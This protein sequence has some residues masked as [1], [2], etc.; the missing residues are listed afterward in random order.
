MANRAVLVGI[1]K[2]KMA[3][4]DLSGC[5]NDVTNVRDSLIKF[6]GF[7]IDDIR[8]ITDDRATKKAIMERLTWLVK[9]A[10][11]AETWGTLVRRVPRRGKDRGT[12]K[13]QKVNKP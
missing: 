2:Y 8:V 3:N 9:G 5:V 1:N 12:A 7:K 4:S 11:A 10:K 13:F 6:F